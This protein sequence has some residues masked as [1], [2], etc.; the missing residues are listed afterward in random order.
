LEDPGQIALLPTPCHRDRAHHPRSPHRSQPLRSIKTLA[1]E[2]SR[3][4]AWHAASSRQP[5]AGSRDRGSG[6]SVAG[7]R[8]SLWLRRGG[9]GGYE[10]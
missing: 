4:P 6:R 10:T 8:M 5:A 7:V 1:D 9:A 2:R 3:Q